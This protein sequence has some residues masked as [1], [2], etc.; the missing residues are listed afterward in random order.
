MKKKILIGAGTLAA[1]LLVFLLLRERTTASTNDIITTVKQGPFKVEIETTG[2]LEAKNS[3]KIL[4][5]T[6]LREFEI[7]QVVIQNIVDEGTVVK[8]GDW[9]ATLDKSTFQTKFVAKQIELEK[10][11]AKYI[12]T[13]LDTT[14]VL[15]EARDQL[16]NL[17]Y[18]VEEKRIVLEQSK[19]EPP[20]TIKQAQIDVEKANREFEQARENYKIKQRQNV[21]KMREQ[22]AVFRKVQDEFSN[23]TSVME[24]FTINAPESGMVIYTKGWD[25]KP[26]KAGSQIQMWDPTVAT[27]P[28]L[29]KMMSKTYVNEVD[30]R[31]V[32]PGQK[33]EVGLDAYPD[34]KLTG[35]VARVANVGEQRPNSDAKVFEVAVEIDGTDPTLRPAMTT[36][37]KIIAKQIDQALFIPLESLHSHADSITF[38]YKRSGMKAQK[39]EVVIGEA[40]NNDVIVVTGLGDKDE[41]YLSVPPDMEDDNISLLKELDGKRKKKDQDGGK[42]AV[43]VSPSASLSHP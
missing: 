26:I 34:K 23:M 12:Q 24:A 42:P 22:S 16:I 30:V 2:E 38:V 21:E 10:E 9:V 25:G 28:D 8:K 14:L 35:I 11:N 36:S 18:A 39:Q 29:T 19:F 27:L 32:L 20:A 5:P 40:N 7:W 13:Q 17:K 31:K 15:R 43:K 41:V 1:L 6:R 37:N 4:G 3:V 33:V